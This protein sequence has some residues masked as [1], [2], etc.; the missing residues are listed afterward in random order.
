[1]LV[2][3]D[4]SENIDGEDSNSGIT[5]K[6]NLGGKGL[7]RRYQGQRRVGCNKGGSKQG[8]CLQNKSKTL[9]EGGDGEIDSPKNTVTKNKG[10]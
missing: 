9:L 6:T 1:M 10:V 3:Q 2:H 5:M 7:I 4:I 8:Q